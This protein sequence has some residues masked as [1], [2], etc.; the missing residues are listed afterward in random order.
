MLIKY[1]DDIFKVLYGRKNCEDTG[2]EYSSCYDYECANIVKDFNTWLKIMK[3]CYMPAIDISHIMSMI[4]YFEQLHIGNNL[5]VDYEKL[6]KLAK[7]IHKE[8]CN[9]R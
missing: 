7:K 9:E 1:L 4:I 6:N 3:E 8:I 2:E 5:K